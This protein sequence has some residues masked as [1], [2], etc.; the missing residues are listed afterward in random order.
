MMR[1]LIIDDSLSMRMYVASMIEDQGFETEMACDGQDALR[2]L[3]STESK[4]AFD[5][6]TVDWDMPIMDGPSFVAAVRADPKYRDMK[7]LMLT[8]RQ[9]MDEVVKALAIGA[10]DYLMKPVT[11]EML[12]EK[13]RLVGLGR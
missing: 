4:G 12:E 9:H 11:P 5:M 8:A 10:D 2:K 13:I 6:A 3:K 1:A 7:L